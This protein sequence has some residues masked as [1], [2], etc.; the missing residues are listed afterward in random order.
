MTATAE[1]SSRYLF[2]DRFACV[3]EFRWDARCAG[4]RRQSQIGA[5]PLIA[6]P[7]TAV[8][9]TKQLNGT[10]VIADPTV[11]ICYNPKE[12]YAAEQLLDDRPERTLFV[13]APT[14]WV[15]ECIAEFDPATADDAS[16]VFRFHDAPLDAATFA[17]VVAL[18]KQCSN[19]TEL[20]VHELVLSIV[21]RIV[22]AGYAAR[23]ARRIPGS[24]GA[25]A[26]RRRENAVVA[27]RELLARR[28]RQRL[29]LANIAEAAGTSAYHLSR[30]FRQRTGNSLHEYQ[31]ELRL[32]D[33]ITRLCD[34]NQPLARL[35]LDLGFSS[36]SHFTTAF[37]ARFGRTPGAFRK[38]I[39]RG[40]ADR[41][42]HF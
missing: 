25:A 20:A 24:S 16:L 40:E 32:R 1:Q 41:R 31:T 29:G 33:A 6:I 15:R 7:L 37:A 23:S 11:A 35:A 13:S 9:I 3:G 12:P 22:T 42:A 18:S 30:I 27:A 21:H 19:A 39:L 36:Q 5:I 8:R 28:F 38:S 34:S 17:R 14:P 10:S 4:Q 26:S 2:R